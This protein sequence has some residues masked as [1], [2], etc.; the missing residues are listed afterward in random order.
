MKIE[1]R[2]LRTDEKPEGASPK[3]VEF[4]FTFQEHIHYLT[5]IEAKDLLTQFRKV[6]T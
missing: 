3:D 2:P 5:E 6:L 4:A 1:F